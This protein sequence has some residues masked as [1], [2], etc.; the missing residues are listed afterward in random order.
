[1]PDSANAPGADAQAHGGSPSQPAVC[2]SVEQRLR[3]LQD[4]GRGLVTL[5]EL[6]QPRGFLVEVD[7]DL[8]LQIGI[9]LI[10][11]RADCCGQLALHA[12][13]AHADSASMLA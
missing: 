7:A 5:L 13:H 2:S 4:L 6:D 10:G 8:G 9:G 11:D 3:H 12:L 1:M